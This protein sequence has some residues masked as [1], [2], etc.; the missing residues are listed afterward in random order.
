MIIQCSSTNT[1]Q[2]KTTT[3]K[4]KQIITCWCQTSL[5]LQPRHCRLG[6]LSSPCRTA[7]SGGSETSEAQMSSS[8]PRHTGTSSSETGTIT[9]LLPPA[10]THTQKDNSHSFFFLFSSHNDNHL[11]TYCMYKFTQFI[12][13]INDFLPPQDFLF[14]CSDCATHTRYNKSWKRWEKQQDSHLAQQTIKLIKEIHTHAEHFS[15]Q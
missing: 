10:A 3:T 9:P 12:V 1:Q 4:N 6:N 5:Q 2:N 11:F 7:Q 15:K 14:C 13:C 8:L